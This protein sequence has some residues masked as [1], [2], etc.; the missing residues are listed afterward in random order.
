[1]NDYFKMT[2][3]QQYRLE[4]SW[5]CLKCGTIYTNPDHIEVPKIPL[6]DCC[7]ESILKDYCLNNPLKAPKYD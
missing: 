2:S 5:K 4:Y 7:K 3:E 1:M 6:C